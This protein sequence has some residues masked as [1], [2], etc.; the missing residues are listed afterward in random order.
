MANFETQMNSRIIRE[1]KTALAAILNFGIVLDDYR[2]SEGKGM[3]QHL[4][5]YY[6]DATS[7]GSLP[8]MNAAQVLFPNFELCDDASMSTEKLCEELRRQRNVLEVREVAAKLADDADRDPMKAMAECHQRLQMLMAL[9]GSKKTDVSFDSALEDILFEYEQVEAG[10]DMSK[11]RWPWP[12]LQDETGGIQKD[13]YIVFYGRP[14]SKKSWVLAYLIAQAYIQ[15][16]SVLVYTKEMTPHNILKRI[17]ACLAFLPYREFRRGRLNVEDRKFLFDLREVVNVLKQSQNFIVLSGKDVTGGGD[18]VPWL[19]SKV[20]KY[21]PSVQFVDGLYLMSDSDA[22]RKNKAA[23]EKMSSISRSYRQLILDTEIP[24]IATL[25]ANRKA[26]GHSNAELDEIAFSD[27]IGQDATMAARVISE[28]T[29]PTIMLK[30]G[31]AREFELHGLRIGGVPAVD[32]TEKGLVSE[33]EITKAMENDAGDSESEKK[34][35]V[36]K[37]RKTPVPAHQDQAKILDKQMARV[38]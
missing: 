19:R 38:G 17:A 20:E 37:P 4:L 25:Q 23:N 21:K 3:F 35:A 6:N 27:A 26:A 11:M 10:V 32:F 24:G 16:K 9:G 30:L 13:D 31:G 8:G 22:G 28:K 36:T 5:A 18:T 15:G 2:S 34:E 33:K 14:K 1:G 7:S 29:S 12:I